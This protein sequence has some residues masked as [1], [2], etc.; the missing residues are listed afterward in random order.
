MTDNARIGSAL[1]FAIHALRVNG[2]APCDLSAASAAEAELRV[3]LD[4]RASLDAMTTLL[5]RA[6]KERDA[7]STELADLKAEL[8]RA[9]EEERERIIGIITDRRNEIPWL[10]PIDQRESIHADPRFI[11]AALAPEQKGE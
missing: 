2:G 4:D 11:R 9:R 8:A 10:T 7:F 3:L 6:R 1:E 5:A